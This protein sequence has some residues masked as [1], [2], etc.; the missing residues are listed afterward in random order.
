MALPVRSAETHVVKLG[1]HL[2]LFVDHHLIDRLDGATLQLQKPVLA[3]VALEFDAP[4]EGAFCGYPTVIHDG[5]LYRLYYRGLPKAGADGSE[6]ESTCYAES[7]D[8]VHWT[9]PD[10]GLFEVNGTRDNNCVLHG[11]APFS[12]NFSPFLDARPGVSAE[13]RFKAIA[14]TAKSGLVAWA[15]G[16]GI[17][18]RKMSEEPVFRDGAFDSQN[19]AFWSVNEGCYV[20]Y[21]RVFTGG[22]ANGERWEPTD[23]RTIARTTSKDF[24]HWTKPARMTFGDTPWEHLYTNQTHPYFR[25]S[26]IY[27]ALAM[28]F[29]P[30]RQVLTEE[31]ARLLHVNK[32]YAGDTAETVLL[33]SRGGT[34]YDRTFM[35]GFIRPGNDLGNWASRAGL[36]ALGVV[37]TGRGEMSI[38]KQAHYAQPTAKLLRYT[39]RTDGFASV[40]APFA[41]GEMIT[42][43]FTFSGG[44]LIINFASGAAGDIRVELQDADGQPVPGRSLAYARETIGDEIERV[45]RWRDG[46]DVSS[47][48]GKVVRLRFVMKDADL[49]SLRFR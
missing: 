44:E 9:K 2:E 23:F 25:E 6:N 13:E 47:F 8:G 37:P 5:K 11:T 45:V 1:S 3:G 7:S 48:S 27:I 10:L 18:W 33:T 38:Y 29:M 49:Y 16:D 36:T 34:S 28:R 26:S 15:S 19:V 24:R 35:E 12:H 20:L 30:G 31:Q 21:F 41:G 42:R 40:H 4:W 46:S 39:L 22:T 32:N 17:H 43:P 14:G